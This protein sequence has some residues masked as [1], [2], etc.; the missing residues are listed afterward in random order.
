M[1]SASRGGLNFL[2]EIS[3]KLIGITVYV[4]A[5]ISNQECNI[6]S[7]CHLYSLYRI[8][9]QKPKTLVEYVQIHDLMKRSTRAKI[10]IYDHLRISRD[11]IRDHSPSLGISQNVTL[12]GSIPIAA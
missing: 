5:S 11:R 6:H 9:E 4:R 8:E 2:R 7:Y 10:V 3:V 1:F 12:A